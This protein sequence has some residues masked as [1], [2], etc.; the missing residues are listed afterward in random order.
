MARA[1]NF[2]PGPAALPLAVL[3]R[4]RDEWLDWNGEG[5]SVIE[6]SHRGRAFVAIAEKAEADLRT[7]MAI[8]DGY[9][10]L[11][12]QGG[13]TQHFAQIPMNL[14]LGRTI[15]YVITGAWGEKA[16]NEAKAVATPRVA[17][18]SKADGYFSIPPRDSWDLDPKAALVHVTPNET[19]GG[20]EFAGD[21]DVGNVP[22]VADFSSSILSRPIDVGRYGV[23]YAGAQKNIGPSGLV[24]LIIRDDLIVRSGGG[25]SPIL[26]YAAHA[27]DGSMLNT[28]NTFAWYLAGLV[29]EW[30]LDQGGIAAIGARNAEKA[31][32][33]YDY[34]DRSGWYSNPVALDAR[35]RMNVPFRLQDPALDDAF[36]RESQAAGL[37]ALKGH[38]SVGGMRASLYNAMP[39]EGVRAL[40]DFMQDF[41]RRHG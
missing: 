2:S 41:Q 27:K 1:F 37:L 28:P 39:I 34:I 23:I 30:L 5:A 22:L 33:L 7:L 40:I 17:A 21:P 14:A 10:V 16:F 36:V 4:A 35:S 15:D 29:F 19:I 26:S 31:A 9:R 18:T 12:L 8:P 20:V 11:F 13:A 25:L 6:L 32:L 24:V 3:E 38:R